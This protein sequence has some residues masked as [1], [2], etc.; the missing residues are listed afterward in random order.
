[1][2]D[3]STTYNNEASDI[4]WA[5][6]ADMRTA[7]EDAKKIYDEDM[8]ALREVNVTDFYSGDGTAENPGVKATL[9]NQAQDRN[10]ENGTLGTL[11]TAADNYGAVQGK[12]ATFAPN[13]TYKGENYDVQ[14][15]NQMELLRGS[16]TGL[17][18]VFNNM[19]V[20]TAGANMANQ[21]A[22]QALAASQD[23]AMQTG[24]GAGG[25]TALAAAAAKSKQGIS[26]DI[27]RQV[28]ANEQMR[29]QGESSLQRELLAQGNTA[30][31]F[32]VGQQQFNTTARNVR[33]QF[34]AQARNTSEQFNAG[35]ANQRSMSIFGAQNDM[36]KFNAGAANTNQLAQF[37]AAENAAAANQQNQQQVN[38]Q[39][40]ITQTNTD[41]AIAGGQSQAESDAA[42]IL[43]NLLDISTNNLNETGV[44][45]AE[46]EA[47][48]G[49][50][51]ATDP[52]PVEGAYDLGAGNGQIDVA[53]INAQTGGN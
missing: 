53:G 17:T 37:Q 38:L 42:D 41:L 52:T 36:E 13:Q 33:E 24:S 50:N 22:D 26:A 1:M 6:M 3:N 20:S 34:G 46:N 8:A 40:S 2:S 12:V 30:S 21:E 15:T 29:L 51:G 47:I 31:T 7:F 9:A 19:Q 16:A 32:N 35:Q 28:K 4:A 5:D 49:I 25:A 48:A 27:D 44:A 45:L 23:L 10:V 39:N 14:Q 18:N 11:G 43:A